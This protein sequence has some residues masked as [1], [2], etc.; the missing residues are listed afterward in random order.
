MVNIVKNI[1]PCNGDAFMKKMVSMA[2][3]AYLGVRTTK[4]IRKI[5]ERLA[6]EGYRTLSQ[7]AEMAIIEWLKEQGHL[8][9]KPNK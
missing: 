8:K 3:D 9:K 6:E 7:Q 1:Y 5:L 2:K 4:E